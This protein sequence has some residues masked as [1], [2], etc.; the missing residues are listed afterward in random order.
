MKK[1]V[2]AVDLGASSGRVCIGYLEAG[3]L[4]VEEVHR[5][6]HESIIE[7]G[8]LH[9][10]WSHIVNEVEVG[11]RKTKE[12]GQLLSVGVDCWA[13]D[14]GLLNNELKLISE[15]YCYRDSRADPF[16]KSIPEK[17]TYDYI[18]EKTGIQYLYFNTI[19]Q[20]AAANSI[21][22]LDGI[23][24]FLMLPDLLNNHLCGSLTNDVTNAS[25][26]QLLNART[27]DWDWELIDKVGLPRSIFPKIHK[28]GEKLG[29][30]SGLADLDGAQV[31]SVASHDT[32]SAVAG[33]PLFPNTQSAYI[34]SGTW[35]LVGLELKEPVTNKK[36][37]KYNITN[38][39]G[40]ED[41]VRFIKNVAGL[42]LI[43]QSLR[44][45]N[46]QGQ[47]LKISDLVT[48]AS[49]LPR[50]RCV[51]DATDPKYTK[52]GPVPEWIMEDA[53]ATGQYVPQTPAEFALAIFESLALAYR[54]VI[55]ELEEASGKEVTEINI[56]GGGS[57]NSLLNQLTADAVG[58][59]VTSGPIEATALAPNME[60]R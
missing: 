46:K 55:H 11:L 59:K 32:G 60:T 44:Y 54:K 49:K 57:A 9:W 13:V 38:E 37:L 5:F 20:L 28:P 3:E 18:Y 1:F 6:S 53:K 31:I 56:V 45:W 19:Y 27:R 17:L 43:E 2:A 8:A 25:T 24:Q 41:T 51:I 30:I 42:W 7:F 50:S 34:S 23:K 33:I 16:F 29:V 35:S 22:E 26:T 39:L 12:L 14:Y 52:P 21:G 48:E 10:Q 36:T 58:L 40:A 47:V 15:P 4:C